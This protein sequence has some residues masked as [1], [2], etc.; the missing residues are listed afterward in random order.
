MY[1]PIPGIDTAARQGIHV[2]DTGFQRARFDAAYLVVEGAHAAFIDCGTNHSIPRLLA[3]LDAQGLTPARVDWLILTH[4]HLD[5]AG[6]AGELMAQL[7][8]ARL[9]VHP[10]GARHM[11]DPSKLW[12]GAAAVYG[13]AE[14][15][16]SYG[17]LRPVPAARV[18]EAP[19]G[20]EVKLAGRVLRCLDTPGHARHHNAIHDPQ[21]GCVFSGDT[22]GLSYREFDT[23]Q[24]PFI[25]PTTSPVQFDPDALHASIR[26]LVALE[27]AAICLT[28]FGPVTDVERLADELHATIDEMVA[29]A[30]RLA[31]ARERHT[32]LVAA[33]AELYV[34]QAHRHGCALSG[35]AVRT[36]LAIDTELNAQGLEVWLDRSSAARP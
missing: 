24:G 16:R 31:D 18:V 13:E 28:H 5:H 33:L 36:L 11:I 8:N 2:I 7:P 12:A 23:D 29:L 35:A 22:F 17:Q 30:H 3:V 20:F 15:Q 6:G 21:S 4:V 10:R 32:K 27:P 14:M 25:I 34:E 26:R 19:D 1:D 9:V